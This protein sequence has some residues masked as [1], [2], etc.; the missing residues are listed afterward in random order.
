[1][2]VNEKGFTLIELIMVIVILGLLAVVAIPKYQD[3]RSEAAK[4]SADGVYAA[5]GAA[6]AI[7]FSTRLVSASRA[8]A[9]T[10]TTTLFAAM[11][12]APQGWSA[13]ATSRISASLGGTTYTIGI[14]TVED[15]GPTRRAVIKKR[16]PAS[17]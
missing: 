17:W 1:M 3:L 4:A 15:A 9:I 6:S 11:D 7:N 12:G 10:N 5:A 13:A 16:A 14:A 8:N 2:G